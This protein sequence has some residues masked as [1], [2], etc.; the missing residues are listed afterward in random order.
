M[1]SSFPMRPAASMPPV[2]AFAACLPLLLCLAC[3]PAA[4]S[5]ASEEGAAGDTGPGDAAPQGEVD[6][7]SGDAEA[8]LGSQDQD[9]SAGANGEDAAA[10]GDSDAAGPGAEEVDPEPLPTL[11][12]QLQWDQQ[13]T[14]LDLHLV[15]NLNELSDEEEFDRLFGDLSEDCYYANCTPSEAS[16]LGRSE[17]D[18]G[19][20]GDDSDNPAL[21]EDDGSQG[22]PETI[23]MTGPADGS[24]SVMVHYNDSTSI[25]EVAPEVELWWGDRLEKWVV[26]GEALRPE[27]VWKAL[28]IQV[29]GG[30]PTVHEINRVV[31]QVPAS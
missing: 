3:Q 31:G 16:A 26:G 18:W 7:G 30:A 9:S 10:S 6:A 29:S 27:D 23:L 19:V 21:S 20:V 14:D 17:L 25:L 4:E 1:P 24:Y 13:N 11:R 15:R 22:G 12:I 2:V 5:T 8:D 28:Q